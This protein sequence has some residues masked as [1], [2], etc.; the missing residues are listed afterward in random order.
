V[1]DY[2]HREYLQAVTGLTQAV[3]RPEWVKADDVGGLT[4]EHL[5]DGGYKVHAPLT[6]DP[7]NSSMTERRVTDVAAQTI[8]DALKPYQN[9]PAIDTIVDASVDT[10]EDSLGE[11]KGDEGDPPTERIIE[12]YN[13]VLQSV[14]SDAVTIQVKVVQWGEIRYLIVNLKSGS[15]VDIQEGQAA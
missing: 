6:T 11:M 13:V 15:E 12:D 2:D 1:A 14:G 3:K 7:N 10:I 4:L 9:K 5:S 8:A